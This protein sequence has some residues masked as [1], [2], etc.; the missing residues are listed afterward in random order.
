MF[1]ITNYQSSLTE[2]KIAGDLGQVSEV[3]Q[4]GE[5]KFLY[6]LRVDENALRRRN[7]N[8][9]PTDFRRKTIE[10]ARIASGDAI[11]NQPSATDSTKKQENIFDSEFGADKNDSAGLGRTY[12]GISSERESSVLDKAK[13]FDYNLKFSVD[14]VT[15]SLFNNDVLITRYQPY[16]GSLPVTLNNGAFNGLASVSIFDL[17]ED[18]RFTG[19]FRSPLLNAA[20]QGVPINVGQDNIFYPGTQSLLNSGSEYMARFDYLKRRI[21]YGMLYYRK[22]DVGN[23]GEIL[24]NY[25][26]TSTRVSLNILLT[27]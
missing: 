17:L 21:D 16:T 3:R 8:A 24:P 22:T 19:M 5:L 9:R 27:G 20:G 12:P 6:K 13:R 23:T 26:L 15:G 1:P 25:S 7:I 11:I 2:T 4:E 10:A 14:Q 18:Y